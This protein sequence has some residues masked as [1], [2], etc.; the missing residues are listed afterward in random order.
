MYIAEG[1]SILGQIALGR[2]RFFHRPQP[3]LQVLSQ[4][5][6][7]EELAR[8]QQGC[9]LAVAELKQLYHRALGQVGERSASIF[10][11]HAM[12]LQDDDFCTTIQSLIQGKGLTAEYAVQVT[13]DSFAAAFSAMDSAYMRAR[14][15]DLRDITLRLIRKLTQRHEWDP[16]GEEPAILVAE[17]FL[18]SEVF[19][20]DNR[21]LLGLI[22]WG[23]S[24]DS[25]TAQL[26]KAVRIPALAEVDLNPAWEGHPALLDGFEG[27]VYVDPDRETT[28]RLRLRY[29]EGG[30]PAGVRV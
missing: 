5:S 4:R 8:F 27:R 18:P 14:S 6:A 25:H 22:T 12:L 9:E 13:G 3:Q 15:V 20:L 23:G 11:I 24:V 19:S 7:A 2:L 21:R 26:L 16:L 28:E 29:Q 17:E 30:R 1:K 10:S